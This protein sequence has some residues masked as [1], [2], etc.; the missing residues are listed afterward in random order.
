[1]FFFKTIV[2]FI[3]D[4][5]YRDLMVMSV[6]VL[7]IGTLV[8]H[9]LEGWGWVDSLY[10]SVITLTTIGYGDFSPATEAGKLF[11]IFYILVG[12]G[13]ILNFINTVYHHYRTQR[14]DLGKEKERSNPLTNN[15]K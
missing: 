5:E 8:Y 2:S 4:K 1:M 10:F 13:L 14:A 11:T 3:K 9:Q 15:G 6:V 12:L 7:G